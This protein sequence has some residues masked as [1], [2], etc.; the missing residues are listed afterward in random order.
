MAKF[1]QLYL[2]DGQWNGQEIVP[3][4]WVSQST[5]TYS[6]DAWDNVGKFRDIGYGYQWWTAR[7]GAHEV[8]FAWGHGG[9]LIV[10][11]DELDLVVVTTADPF[12]KQ[13]DGQSWKHEKACFNL[14]GRFIGS[15]P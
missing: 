5:A 14:V 13:H 12:W 1:G 11:V 3:S 7:A 9:Q 2:D 10:L 8:V 15:F 4:V 6:D